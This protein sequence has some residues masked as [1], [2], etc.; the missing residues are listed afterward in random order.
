[1]Y[2]QKPTVRR[3]TG[4]FSHT[5]QMTSYQYM[6]SGI[7]FIYDNARPHWAGTAQGQLRRFALEI[8]EL[9]NLICHPAMITSIPDESIFI[10]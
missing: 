4:A 8:V 6:S 2:T 10:K 7:V 3:F 9:F 1:M 5:K